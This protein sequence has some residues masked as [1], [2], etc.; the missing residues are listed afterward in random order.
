MIIMIDIMRSIIRSISLDHK[1][2]HNGSYDVSYDGSYDLFL[3]IMWWCIYIYT[4]IH[5]YTHIYI[6]IHIYTHTSSW[7]QKIIDVKWCPEMLC[8]IV[9]D[10]Q[11]P[12]W[13]FFFWRVKTCYFQGDCNYPLWKIH[14]IIRGD[15]IS[16]GL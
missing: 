14:V 13:I 1:G 12:H 9:S 8:Q 6:Y 11:D 5:I 7:N 2:H 16:G 10:L 4:C 3:G 15:V